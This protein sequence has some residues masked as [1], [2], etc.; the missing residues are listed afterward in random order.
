MSAW[1][2]FQEKHPSI[3][4]WYVLLWQHVAHI[5][6]LI[7]CHMWIPVPP[8]PLLDPKKRVANGS[9]KQ[10]GIPIAGCA[11]QLDTTRSEP[12]RGKNIIYSILETGFYLFWV[13]MCNTTQKKTKRLTCSFFSGRFYERLLL[14][15]VPSH[16]FSVVFGG[17]VIKWPSHWVS[18]FVA[19]NLAKRMQK[20]Q[21]WGATK[22]SGWIV[23]WWDDARQEPISGPQENFNYWPLRVWSMVWN[24]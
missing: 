8:P 2:N 9:S 10:L 11:Q 6:A 14:K 17:R 18:Y 7:K 5:A 21:F 23:R 4:Y 19:E 20:D 12:E 16:H 15:Y 24:Q 1:W 13:F 3:M 22:L